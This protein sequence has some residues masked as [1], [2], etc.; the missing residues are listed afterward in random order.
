VSFLYRPSYYGFTEFE[1]GMSTKGILEI[2]F[3]KYRN[4]KLG[5]IKLKHDHN[6]TKISDFD[7]FNDKYNKVEF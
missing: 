3:R 5:D 7:E 4:G 6:F 2:L 1:D